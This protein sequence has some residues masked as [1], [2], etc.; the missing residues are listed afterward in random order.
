MRALPASVPEFL[1]GGAAHDAVALLGPEADRMRDAGNPAD[2]D[3]D[4]AHFVDVGDDGTVDG[5]ALDA[6]PS[7]RERYDTALR[8]RG[9]DQYRV[10]YL[11]YA[12]ADGYQHLVRDFLYWRIDVAGERTAAAADRAFFAQDRRLRESLIVRDV[13]YWGHFVA[14]GSQPL[15]C[16]VHFNGWNSGTNDRYPNPRGWSDSHTI[17]SRFE[18]VLVD[19]VASEDAVFARVPAPAAPG[20]A[21]LAEAGRYLARSAGEVE[22]VY[23]LE[24]A[25]AIDRPTA[26][27]TAFVLDRL[28][29]GAAE[30]RNLVVAAWEASARAETAYPRRIRASDFESGKVVPTPSLVGEGGG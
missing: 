2:A 16:S 27:S 9:S 15:H 29:A 5:I 6:L 24:A 25:G 3:D 20:D 22:R 19:R 7:S 10:G 23:A 30:L 4:Q 8:A 28:A 11:P 12:I 21:I 13:G 14:D 1:R 26:A 17:H 18:T